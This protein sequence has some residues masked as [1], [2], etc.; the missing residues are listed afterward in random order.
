MALKNLKITIDDL[1]FS[2]RMHDGIGVKT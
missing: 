1:L 2:K